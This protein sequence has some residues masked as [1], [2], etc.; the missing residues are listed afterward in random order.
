MLK[1][2]ILLSATALALTGC[3]V[4]G[5][6]ENHESSNNVKSLEFSVIKLY[7]ATNFDSAEVLDNINK[8][9]KT[10]K[11]PDDVLKV[12]GT[13]FTDVKLDFNLVEKRN[14]DFVATNTTSYVDNLTEKGD[15]IP[16]YYNT[17]LKG[18]FYIESIDNDRY[19]FK[20]NIK[21]SILKRIET[22]PKNKIVTNPLTSVREFEQ[23]VVVDG[24]MNTAT[25]ITNPE[26]KQYELY[27]FKVS[28]EKK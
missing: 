17:G 9:L 26:P 3:A 27:I 12:Y 4:G 16:G 14:I 18:N 2:F 25:G 22:S 24:D 1:K 13:Y 20:Y 6:N 8:E 23:S 5:K 15:I 10:G 21:N 19:V 7:A 28:K 11:T